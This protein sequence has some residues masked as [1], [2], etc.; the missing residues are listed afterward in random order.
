MRAREVVCKC[1]VV[2]PFDSFIHKTE[3]RVDR[4]TKTSVLKPLELSMGLFENVKNATLT[5]RRH[6]DAAN[7]VRHEIRLLPDTFTISKE[8]VFSFAVYK[9][10]VI[11]G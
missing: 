7:A 3:R 6:H 9:M 2:D 11:L 4:V 5:K 8:A 1:T 10:H